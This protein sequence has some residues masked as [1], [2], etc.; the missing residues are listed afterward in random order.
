MCLFNHLFQP[1]QLKKYV[2]LKNEDIQESIKNL[3]L[4]FQKKILY[5][6]QKKSS[7]LLLKLQIL[8]SRPWLGNS[9]R[10]SPLKSFKKLKNVDRW[11]R[12]RYRGKVFDLIVK[13]KKNTKWMKPILHLRKS[14]M[15]HFPASYNSNSYLIQVI[16]LTL[17]SQEAVA[18]TSVKKVFVE[19]LQNSLENTCSRVPFLIKLQGLTILNSPP[20]HTSSTV[21]TSS[22]S[23][24]LQESADVT[25]T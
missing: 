6:L 2:T 21:P 7:W 4:F 11:I 17:I 15:A 3:W 14:M 9:Y 13:T 5:N 12:C 22:T 25:I 20:T 18:Q 1:I 16:T 19:I 23:P 8:T 10:S 24:I